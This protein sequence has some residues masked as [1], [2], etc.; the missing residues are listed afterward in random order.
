[1]VVGQVIPEGL[2]A[3]LPGPELATTLAGLELTRVPN[4]DIGDVLVAQSRQLAH[5][6]ARMFAT[7]AEVVCRR[8]FAGPLEVRRAD[9]P[10]LYGADEVR[11]ALAWTRRAAESETD[12]AFVLVYALPQVQAA[13]SQGHIDRGKARIFAQH[14]GDLPADQ[15]AAICAAVL[16][17]APR[18]TT[19]QIAE[20]IKRLVLELDP[21]Y[22]ERRYRKAIRDRQVVAYLCA[23]G[24]AVLSASGLPADEAAAA[25]ERLDALARAARHDGHPGTLD[26]VRAD[27][28]LGL[29][30]GSLHGLD[31]AEILQALLERF[32]G[33]TDLDTPSSGG[34]DT[35]T[36]GSGDAGSGEPSSEEP[37]SGA[38]MVGAFG[39]AASG[40]PGSDDP[41]A[42]DPAS[43]E[44]ESNE[45]TSGE[46]TSGEAR[47]D[48]PV[49]EEPESGNPGSDEPEVGESGSGGPGPDD[50]G[51][52]E[53]GPGS[54]SY[55]GP[56]GPEPDG[57]DTGGS[58][59]GGGDLDTRDT[60]EDARGDAGRDAA[61]T[62]LAAVADPASAPG[63]PAGT[64]GP[65]VD[66]PASPAA[67]TGASASAEQ[68]T[69]ER[70]TPEENQQRDPRPAPSA[71]AASPSSSLGVEVR[72]PLS[73]LLGLDDRAGELPGWGPI[74]ADAAR[75]IVARQRRAQWRWVI[76]DDHG[77][78]LAE[79]ITR[80]RP[81]PR[82]P[83]GPSGGVV[84]LQIPEALLATLAATAAQYGR[85]AGVITD[86]AARYQLHRQQDELWAELDAD[87]T[88]RFP[89]APLRRH[90]E[91]RDRTCVHPGCRTSARRCDQDHTLDHGRG[92][93]TTHDDLAPLC[94]HH[95]MLKTKGGWR[96]EQPEPGHFIWTSPLGRHYPVE[97]EPILPPPIRP[98]H[99]DPE[100]WFDHPAYDIDH[101]QPDLRRR[102][103]A[104]PGEDHA[105]DAPAPGDT[106]P[107][108]DEARD[109]PPP[110]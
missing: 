29:L 53:P 10:E 95:H 22:Y 37:G 11:A 19:G 47:S 61:V 80:H 39:A 33:H 30:D 36:P 87:P 81:T 20:R 100:P 101:E 108:G 65:P 92:G 75:R 7:M 106:T 74:P 35:G 63:P 93:T 86:I 55:P 38:A 27:L 79:G 107:R 42:G 71:T 14:L 26:Q 54:G 59:A 1:M 16:P 85:W 31:R 3:L 62:R 70:S 28:V 69:P 17:H 72:V 109:D 105:P 12:L 90:T 41:V 40:D 57:P 6:Q 48:V 88:A 84:E 49:P 76:V 64:P 5:E 23:D 58:P 9:T 67:A 60:R 4:D 110:F 104:P 66:A 34:P 102:E 46:P 73:T 91:V 98:V 89:S 51:L 8:P 97:P 68:D 25:W 18:L 82:D 96:L 103:R 99:R 78:L 77:H 32:A 94:R 52:D 15:I 44:A 2:A 13:L 21:A 45:P 43:S 56:G 83:S 50:P 24:T